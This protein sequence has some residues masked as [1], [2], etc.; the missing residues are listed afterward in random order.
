MLY[1]P[2]IPLPKRMVLLVHSPMR[3]N[4]FNV[5]GTG[6]LSERVLSQLTHAL[7]SNAESV[8]WTPG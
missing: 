2:A 6:A 7:H 3:R 4:R 8:S 1:T 5:G